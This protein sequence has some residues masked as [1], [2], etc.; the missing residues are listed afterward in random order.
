MRPEL[1]QLQRRWRGRGLQ[2]DAVRSQVI[3]WDSDEEGVERQ[4]RILAPITGGWTLKGILGGKIIRFSLGRAVRR[5]LGRTVQRRSVYLQW[6]TES[7]TAGS[8]R[9]THSTVFVDFR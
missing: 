4:S 1:L 8:C 5:D 9:W 2:S 7:L 6:L 3:G